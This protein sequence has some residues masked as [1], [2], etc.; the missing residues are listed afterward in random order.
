MSMIERRLKC[1]WVHGFYEVAYTEWPGPPGARTVL[2]VHGL[3]RN[4][5]DFD[6]LAE[7]LSANFR[8]I[9]PDMPGRR[10]SDWLPDP[11]TYNYHFYLATLATLIARLDV[12]EIDWVGTSMGG[13][14]GFFMAGT[15]GAPVRRLVVNDIGPLIAK[16]GI[17]RIVTYTGLDKSFRTLEE[18]ETELRKIAAG[19]GP[20][21]DEEWRHLASN[22]VRRKPDGS[23]AFAYDPHIA[24]GLRKAPIA[25]I[26][27]WAHWDAVRCPTL[28]LR[29]ETSDV[30]RR[31][32]AEAMTKR[33]PPSTFIEFAGVGHAPALMAEDQIA[34]VRDFLLA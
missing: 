10:N 3:T 9:C 6:H 25:D 31:S 28:V 27:L 5:R 32:D 18:L 2:C 24:D 22:S 17:A 15:K 33:G 14:L 30:L 26:D 34:A 1:M 11:D 21:T 16:E 29:G 12:E 13:I 4:G 20:L 8:V 7:V 23:Y 19:F